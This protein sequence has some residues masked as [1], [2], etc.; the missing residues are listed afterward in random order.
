[1]K[2]IFIISCLLIGFWVFGNVPKKD[3]LI[4]VALE[5]IHQDPDVTIKIAENL[6]KNTQDTD[7][8][9]RY[10]G[11]LSTAYIGKRDFESSLEYALKSQDL[12]HETNNPDTKT[13][14]LLSVAIQYQQME[15]FSKSLELLDDLEKLSSQIDNEIQK[16]SLLG[17]ANAVRGMIYKSQ[18]NP[19]LALNK[20]L[21]AVKHLQQIL[22]QDK[23]E[24]NLSVVFYNIG[25]CYVE[26]GKSTDAKTAFNQSLKFAKQSKAIS[27]E[28]FAYKGLS[29]V[30]FNEGQ[31]QQSLDLLNLA[32]QS[33]KNV[34]DL[35]LDEGIYKGKADNFLALNMFD[36]YQVYN[37]NYLKTRF[38]REQN[39]LKSIHNSIDNQM[40]VS[41]LK[42][43]DIK[44][45]HQ[46]INLL[47]VSLALIICVILII[48][49]LKNRKLNLQYQTRIKDLIN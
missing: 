14:I 39:E 12:L 7:E 31:H 32:E 2:K 8:K 5:N 46:K 35:L 25:Y 30:Y 47:I 20:F 6:L 41:E 28:G 23:S 11:L 48:L 3:S 16:H 45:K 49:I 43:N 37:D 29:D 15:L 26:I 24:A 22:P 4:Q 34:G 27:L 9:A 19:D 10:Y 44:N 36:E 33:A 17:K 21:I 38:V 18:S 13:K 42:L 40:K 1:M